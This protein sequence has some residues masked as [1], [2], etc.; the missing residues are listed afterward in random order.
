MIYNSPF[1]LQER[2]MRLSYTSGSVKYAP[3]IR[4][5]NKGQLAL[6]LLQATINFPRHIR[7]LRSCR[8]DPD[9]RHLPWLQLRHW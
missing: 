2:I 8:R 4:R 6:Q 5:H 1:S 3:E 9:S 7:R